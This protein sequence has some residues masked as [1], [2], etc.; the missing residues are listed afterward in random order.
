MKDKAR[1]TIK[2]AVTMGD[3]CT[4][5]AIVASVFDQKLF[6][7][8]TNYVTVEVENKVWSDSLHKSVM[9]NFSILSLK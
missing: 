3:P 8:I 4:K 9:M 6:N 7:M 2:A 1:G 5:G